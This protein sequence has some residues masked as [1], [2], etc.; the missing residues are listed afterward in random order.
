[1]SIRIIDTLYED[2]NAWDWLQNESAT[3][4]WIESCKDGSVYMLSPDADRAGVT[5]TAAAVLAYDALDQ[6]IAAPANIQA[7]LLD[8]QILDYELSEFIGGFE[9]GE[10]TD[11]PNL[12][13]TY[14]AFKA[15][16]TLATTTSANITAAESFILN[17]QTP[18]GSFA[19]APAFSTGSLLYSGYACEILSMTGFDGALS[20][21]SSSVDPH[22]PDGVGFDWRSYVIVGIVIVALVLAVL[23]VRS[24]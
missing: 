13:S 21:L 12:L 9:E 23:G 22:S 10:D 1:M 5:A 16:E 8:R 18:E 20:I 4:D 6:A 17:C 7:W 19:S 11:A 24:D 15:L 2:E 14:F 3:I